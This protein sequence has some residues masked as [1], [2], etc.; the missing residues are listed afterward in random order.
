[1]EEGKTQEVKPTDMEEGKTQ[2]VKPTDKVRLR[3]NVST[4]S[5]GLYS[6][7]HTAEIIAE[8]EESLFTAPNDY[9]FQRQVSDYID[10]ILSASDNMESELS[11]RYASRQ[12][13]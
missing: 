12:G 13:V 10:K 4:T 8:I 7:D 9:A 11:S 6:W 3:V 5:K 2:E 1:M